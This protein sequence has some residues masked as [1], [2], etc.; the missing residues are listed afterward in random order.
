ME[1]PALLT[2]SF[3]LLVAGHFLQ[4]LGYASMLLLPLYLNHLGASRTE[5]G[6]VMAAAAFGGL[7]SRPLVGWALDAW[8]RRPTL[9]VGTCAL[10]SAMLLLGLVRDLS[11]VVYLD[12]M[13]FGIG[14]G[15]LFTGYFAFAA[16][17]I[18]TSRRTEGLALFGV[19]G[20][21]PLVVNPFAGEIGIDPPQLR[22]FFPVL[23]VVVASSMLAVWLLR[24]PTR[25]PGTVG[26]SW[27]Q[28]PRALGNPRLWSAWLATIFFAGLVSIFFAFAT[29]TAE[30]RGV[31]RPAAL[32]LTYALGAATV[33]ILG[34][35]L[36]DRVGPTNMV[37]PALA[38]YIAATLLVAR[39]DSSAAFMIAGLV[40]GIG[41]GYCFPVL[42]SQIVT[43]APTALR[44]SA[45]ALFT[46]LW[47]LADLVA[48]P[49]L[50]AVADRWGDGTMF[51]TAAVVS[52]G[53][54][55][56]WAA[57]EHRFGAGDEDRQQ[58]LDPD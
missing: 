34:G 24:E 23:G 16:D 28:V 31:E 15:A 42:T 27:R 39:A 33:R 3:G 43:R 8:G 40:A 45:L 46:G 47:S 14:Q 6:A 1:R 56:V 18:P 38:T 26:F 19:S 50:G 49:A 29:V 44:G 57:L 17:I 9:L 7:L 32:W 48:R 13:L 52:V 58:P 53:G 55:V 20:L 5:I 41:H 4:A 54:L 22:L 30:A 11:V 25:P 10:A 21:L 37:A 51:A 35:R 2:R 12:R 36:P